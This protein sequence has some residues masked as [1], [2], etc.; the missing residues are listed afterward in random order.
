MFL[1]YVV[2][3]E[4]I[5][6][7]VSHFFYKVYNTESNLLLIQVCRSCLV[8]DLLNETCQLLHRQSQNNFN[9]DKNSRDEYFLILIIIIL[10]KGCPLFNICLPHGSKRQPVLCIIIISYGNFTFSL[11]FRNLVYFKSKSCTKWHPTFATIK[12][13]LYTTPMAVL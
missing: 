11:L 5:F 7:L 13:T 12:A 2:I 1:V 8:D 3:Y 10:A 6:L 9:Y 4:M